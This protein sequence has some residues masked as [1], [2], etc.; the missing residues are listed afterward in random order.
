[1]TNDKEVNDFS[2]GV[3]EAT[4]NVVKTIANNFAQP[5]SSMHSSDIIQPV[6][7]S[8]LEVSTPESS[9]M[10]SIVTERAETLATSAVRKLVKATLSISTSMSS[11]QLS[12]TSLVT[13]QPSSYP[14]NPYSVTDLPVTTVPSTTSFEAQD[15]NEIVINNASEE[16][17]TTHLPL[18]D[19]G[20]ENSAAAAHDSM[21]NHIQNLNSPHSIKYL[22]EVR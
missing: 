19:I 18:A 15:L 14:S 13:G 7:Q 2:S 5:G 16:R 6:E 8:N 3:T 12:D 17:Y 4:M 22:I 1:M 11:T 21:Q 9:T 20:N 10:I